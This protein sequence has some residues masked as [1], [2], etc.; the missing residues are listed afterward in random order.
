MEPGHTHIRID[1]L[2]KERLRDLARQRGK[3]MSRT[4]RDLVEAAAAS[5][6]TR[7]QSVDGNDDMDAWWERASNTV[8]NVKEE[9]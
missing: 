3:T 7:G 5:D 2:T 8:S 1:S 4:L 9:L 6:P